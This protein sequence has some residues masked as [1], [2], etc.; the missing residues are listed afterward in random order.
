M[1]LPLTP[2]PDML[3]KTNGAFYT[4]PR[5][6][7]ITCS[8]LLSTVQNIM[9]YPLSFPSFSPSE[10][11]LASRRTPLASPLAPTILHPLQPAVYASILRMLFA[12]PR[13]SSTRDVLLADLTGLI[14]YNLY[15]LQVGYVDTNDEELCKELEVD[16][17][18][19]DALQIVKGWGWDGAWREEEEW[20][21][22][23]LAAVVKGW[24]DLDFL[25]WAPGHHNGRRLCQ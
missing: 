25:P 9:L 6:H 5:I 15:D 1:G 10:L 20:M 14:G 23:A 3:A 7:R 13:F 24:G 21:G 11:T 12:Y 4:K 2:P 22:D 18:I 17:R 16:R 8:T 19:D